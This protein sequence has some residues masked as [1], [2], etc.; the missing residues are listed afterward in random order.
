[1]KTDK[2]D[3]IIK[4]LKRLGDAGD[5]YFISRIQNRSDLTI[6][7]NNGKTEEINTA[8]SEGLGIQVFDASGYMGFAAADQ[9]SEAIAQKLFEKAKY[10]AA[11]SKVYQGETNQEIYKLAPLN[12]KLDF[13]LEY[14]INSVNLTDLELKLIELNKEIS[15]IDNRLSVRTVLKIVEE[16]WRICR[17]DGTD[18]AFS[19]PRSFVF[20]SITAKQGLDTATTS[21]NLPGNDL[22]IIMEPDKLNK[23]RARA[24]KAANLALDL[25]GAPKCP[26]GN[27]KLVIDYALAKGLAHEAFGHAAETDAIESSI[28]GENGKFRKGMIVADRRLSIIDGPIAG[29]YAYQPIS[30]VG[31]ERQTVKIVDHGVLKAGLAD[32]FSASRAGVPP[33]GAERVESFFHLPIARM[34]NIHIEF[35]DP[36]PVAQEFETV[37]ATD[38]QQI[39]YQHQLAKPGEQVLYLTGF[40]GG[41]VNPAFGDF[42]FNCSAIY[43]LSN[44]NDPVLYKPAIFSGQILSVLNSVS[45]AIG[46]L[47][48]DA[49]GTCGKMGQGVPSCGGSHKFLVIEK[50]PDIM[51]GGE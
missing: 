50:N 12:K 2:Y 14:P 37:T 34:S 1:M 13:Q 22:A 19:T 7:I 5:L 3:S 43:D 46:E 32:I 15:A 26:A 28:L 27:Y 4:I 38:L 45:A 44:E 35:E 8:N 47:Q 10:L 21:A 18:V 30:A 9:V 42:V 6:H 36:I 48:I 41:Q 29:D 49:M 51:I 25:L 24:K 23:L 17:A 33:T 20:H 40:Q 16:E 31:I 11:Q 39:L